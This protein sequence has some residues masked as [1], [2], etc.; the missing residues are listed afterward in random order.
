MNRRQLIA[1]GAALACSPVASPVWAQSAWPARPL[2]MV[3]PFPP[4]GPTDAFARLYASALGQQLG[5]PVVLENKAGASGAVGALEVR[6]SAPD[7]YTLL[8]GTASTHVLYNLIQPKPQFDALADFAWV[9]VL[10]GAPLVFAV[11]PQMPAT[12]KELVARSRAQP[13][14]LSYGSPGSGTMMHIAAERLKQLTGAQIAHVPY[15]GSAPARQDLLGARC[16]WRSIR[17]GRCCRSI[18]RARRAS[19]ASQVLVVPPRRLIS[20]RWP[21]QLASPSPSRPC[22]GM[23]SPC[24]AKHRPTWFA[25]S[26]RRAVAR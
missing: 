4:G 7:G 11:H 26:P 21:S 24:R 25:R 12:L 18:R 19:S 17:L 2:R 1:A 3:I 8:F 15:K 22:S 14:S 16:R 9:G 6:R 23:W 10:G 13:G 20:R 5:Q